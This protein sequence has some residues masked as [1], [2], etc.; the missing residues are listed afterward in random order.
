MG[1]IYA[2][3]I[4]TAIWLGKESAEQAWKH[5][6]KFIDKHHAEAIL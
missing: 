3:A 1:D 5:D 4:P 2:S 6:F